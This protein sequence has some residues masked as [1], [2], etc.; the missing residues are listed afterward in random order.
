MLAPHEIAPA[1]QSLFEVMTRQASDIKTASYNTSLEKVLRKKI[2]SSIVHLASR[3]DDAALRE[4]IRSVRFQ[5]HNTA[6]LSLLGVDVSQ[7]NAKSLRRFQSKSDP[8]RLLKVLSRSSNEEGTRYL[9]L[10]FEGT[11]HADA[12]DQQKEALAL[13][14]LRKSEKATEYVDRVFGLVKKARTAEGYVGNDTIGGIPAS[15][16]ITEII[17]KALV[18][19][20]DAS[21]DLDYLL[22][23]TSVRRL[24]NTS[25]YGKVLRKALRRR[26][27]VAKIAGTEAVG[28]PPYTWARRSKSA[29]NEM[30]F[31]G[32]KVLDIIK[33]DLAKDRSAQIGSAEQFDTLM[34]NVTETYSE[35]VDMISEDE[36]KNDTEESRK[37]FSEIKKA[38]EDD[39]DSEDLAEDFAKIIM[40]RIR[41]SGMSRKDTR[42]LLDNINHFSE[43][44]AL[45]E[46]ARE[47]I[48]DVLFKR[49]WLEDY[50]LNYLDGVFD[51]EDLQKAMIVELRKLRRNI[52]KFPQLRVTGD[53]AESIFDS[54]ESA[55]DQADSA[56]SDIQKL[57]SRVK[58]L[59]DDLYTKEDISAYLSFREIFRQKE[60]RGI[61]G[62]FESA[63]AKA[64][65]ALDLTQG[66]E[67]EEIAKDYVSDF[68]DFFGD[69]LTLLVEAGKMTPENFSDLTTEVGVEVKSTPAPIIK[70]VFKPTVQESRSGSKYLKGAHPLNGYSISNYTGKALEPDVGMTL[71]GQTS[72]SYKLTAL[73]ARVSTQ[74]TRALE[75]DESFKEEVSQ[76]NLKKAVY[77]RLLES[78]GIFASSKEEAEIEVSVEGISAFLLQDEGI[79]NNFRESLNDLIGLEGE[80]VKKRKEAV[81]RIVKDHLKGN[82]D[83]LA[84]EYKRVY[85]SRMGR[86]VDSVY[87]EVLRQETT[88]RQRAGS[89]DYVFRIQNNRT[90]ENLSRNVT[91]ESKD[92]E[93]RNLLRADRKASRSQADTDKAV[94]GA[95]NG[96]SAWLKE[97]AE[98][99]S[100]LTE[101]ADEKN[102]SLEKSKKGS[103][104]AGEVTPN[105]VRSLLTGVGKRLRSKIEEDYKAKALRKT[106]EEIAQD[107]RDTLSALNQA[108]LAGVEPGSVS[109]LYRTL[110]SG[111]IQKADRLIRRMKDQLGDGANEAKKAIDDFREA[112]ILG[113]VVTFE[114]R[115]RKKMSEEAE[116]IVSETEKERE[117]EFKRLSALKE[118]SEEERNKLAEMQGGVDSYTSKISRNSGIMRADAIKKALSRA[119]AE[120]S[121]TSR[122]RYAPAVESKGE[123]IRESARKM[124]ESAV[125]RFTSSE[126]YDNPLADQGEDILQAGELG[127]AKS[128]GIK[129][130]SRALKKLH[131]LRER[132]GTEIP[133]VLVNKVS[134]EQTDSMIAFIQGNPSLF[135]SFDPSRDSNVSLAYLKTPFNPKPQLTSSNGDVTPLRTN[136]FQDI[137]YN[138]NIRS[139]VRTLYASANAELLLKSGL[140]EIN[141]TEDQ[142]SFYDK[143]FASAI[144]SL[145]RARLKEEY[146]NEPSF[147][148]DMF[149]AKMKNDTDSAY[150]LLT[151]F[152]DQAS[153]VSSGAAKLQ[154]QVNGNYATIFGNA[155]VLAVTATSNFKGLLSDITLLLTLSKLLDLTSMSESEVAS[156]GFDPN[157]VIEFAEIFGSDKKDLFAGA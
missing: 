89:E 105:E 71:G 61:I 126:V 144:G 141:A 35:L 66:T 130:R 110:K 155:N 127:K 157:K 60:V 37:S 124:V 117:K 88:E 93:L 33:T 44:A 19:I 62:F 34:E 109:G 49:G 120:R 28:K 13:Q 59:G 10:L 87:E 4:T 106:E 69:F 77:D 95:L 12:D 17:T 149:K 1:F 101:V 15:E 70:N 122:A 152:D 48:Y 103:Y 42:W 31:L 123:A 148:A 22:Q 147:D 131:A 112:M 36:V 27:A 6:L 56:W 121:Q 8:T 136:V 81:D 108:D 153:L 99:D 138:N 51:E 38:Y 85:L 134:E 91:W 24:S 84:L 116:K 104:V 115:I 64:Q 9:D 140:V 135:P 80:N 45:Q 53:D 98:G 3:E 58:A 73:D 75:L 5:I 72:G 32:T 137:N 23:A 7:M 26:V 52:R 90:L 39:P 102:L 16:Y 29:L 25:L 133:N 111:N 50:E 55:F 94:A 100:L 82:L 151:A 119:R 43:E 97:N 142:K 41:T 30:S 150:Y 128:L 14:F 47:I 154:S 139:F 118:P 20:E 92:L 63:I 145:V 21:D 18:G 96:L 79:E 76:V 86:A 78:L 107:Q 2:A 129:E 68:K 54:I 67:E 125:E 114:D 65:Q 132:F 83:R 143:F 113:N 46:K 146:G 57:R 40:T 156:A 11:E 74:V